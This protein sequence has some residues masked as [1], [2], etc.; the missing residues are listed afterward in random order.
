[1][2]P[3]SVFVVYVS[4]VQF[5]ICVSVIPSSE[6]LPI[7]LYY[8]LSPPPSRFAQTLIYTSYCLFGARI[9]RS[10]EGLSEGAVTA[11]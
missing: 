5:G 3:R 9:S 4:H 1:L 11:L 10:E 6:L 7:V 8:S 2:L